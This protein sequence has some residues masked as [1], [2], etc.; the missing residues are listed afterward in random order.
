MLNAE[1]QR[2]SVWPPAAK[3]Y[4]IDTVLRGRP[5]PKIYLRTR[6]DLR[7]RRSYREVID[8]QQRLKAIE[9]F[10]NNQFALGSKHDTFGEFAGMTYADLDEE[11]K[12]GFLSYQIGVEQLFNAS[13]EEVLDIFH[14]LNA[15]G[16]DVNSQELRHGRY[17]GAFRSAVAQASRRW[18]IL[19]DKY[20][21]V[22]LRAR[23]RMAD[24]ELMAQMFGIVLEGVVDGGQ[25]AINK[26]YK[27]YD[28]SLPSDAANKVDEIIEYILQEFSEILET[29]L[30]RGPHFLM[31][32][33]AV[34]HA[35]FG[36]P[37]GRVADEMPRRAKDA[38]TD[39]AAVRAN[40]GTLADVLVMDVT[41]VPER[42]KAFKFASAGSTQRIKSR[43]E[44]L[45][46]LYRAL[47]PDRI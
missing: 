11:A 47:L 13:D 18:A 6:T 10:A 35:L 37:A 12:G 44:R 39:I 15:Y 20:K 23:V 38:L 9:D 32:F 28:G 21:V 46:P 5:M 26:L 42:L 7:T 31:L 2:R 24:D 33:A 40:L 1:F 17:Q 22:G 43:K 30:A 14:R 25:P 19:W 3:A 34:G 41:D 45:I 16:L 36:I 8:G 27:S 29:G 4:L